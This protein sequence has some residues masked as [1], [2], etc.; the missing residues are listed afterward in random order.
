MDFSLEGSYWVGGIISTRKITAPGAL[1]REE[2]VHPPPESSDMPQIFVLANVLREGQWVGRVGIYLFED[3]NE[4]TA[5][6]EGIA[7]YFEYEGDL[8]Q[9]G[10]VVERSFSSTPMQS[11]SPA[12]VSIAQVQGSVVINMILATGVQYQECYDGEYA[13]VGRAFVSSALSSAAIRA[14]QDD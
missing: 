5:Y 10:L 13:E 3:A 7:G 8:A 14:L 2:F 6:L 9:E 4:A 1:Q 11:A 12:Y